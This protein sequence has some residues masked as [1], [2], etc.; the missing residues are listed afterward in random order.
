MA[1]EGVYAVGPKRV[2]DGPGGL[3]VKARGEAADRWAHRSMK[4]R[5]RSCMFYVPKAPALGIEPKIGRCR[6]HAPVLAG[7]PAVYPDD[8]CGDH[9]ISEDAA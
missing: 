1:D 9:K 4:M 5:C 2:E 3:Y 7:F 8:W 6:K